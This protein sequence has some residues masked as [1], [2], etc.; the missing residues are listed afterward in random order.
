M[1]TNV[2]AL[3]FP[4]TPLP[5]WHDGVPDVHAEREG[6]EPTLTPYGTTDVNCTSRPVMIICPGGAYRLHAIHEG[7]DY[8]EW[9]ASQGVV[10][11][12]LTYRLGIHG[13]RYPDAFDD[14]ARS[15]RLIRRNAIAWNLDP[16]RVGV[17]GSSAGGHVVSTLLTH[18]DKGRPDRLD[19]IERESCRP[20]IGVLCYPVISMGQNTHDE[21]RTNLLGSAPPADLVQF[22]SS[23]LQVSKEVPPCFIWHTFADETVKV[24]NSLSF[25][26]ALSRAGVPFELHV[27]ETGR[28]GMGLE[29]VHSWGDSCIRWLKS[30]GFISS[31]QLSAARRNK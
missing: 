8:A 27:Y 21:S 3:A 23:E 14:L 25:A 12:V 30:R 16:E 15:V 26:T 10:C 7:K 11:F 1:V 24:E 18:F 2:N 20:D 29:T 31:G 9:L 6:H 22:L 4:S 17:M 19:P 28:H 5:V 13:H